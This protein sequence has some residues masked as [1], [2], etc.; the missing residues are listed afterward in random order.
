MR[1]LKEEYTSGNVR[2]KLGCRG[3]DP[4]E[5]TESFD[6]LHSMDD[7]WRR[8]R[9]V[10]PFEDTESL[11]LNAWHSCYTVVVGALIQG[12]ILKVICY[13][14]VD[15]GQDMERWRKYCKSGKGCTEWRSENTR[16]YA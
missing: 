1:I 13:S 6:P 12:S 14:K 11:L 7:A 2:I 4:F 16:I 5:D 10:D 9:G 15:P 8:C 3:I